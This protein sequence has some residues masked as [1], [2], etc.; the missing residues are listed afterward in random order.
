MR[1][2]PGRRPGNHRKRRREGKTCGN[3]GWGGWPKGSL[4]VGGDE[5]RIHKH[6]QEEIS[7]LDSGLVS[8][9]EKRVT[10]S[11]GP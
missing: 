11:G 8:N 4:R 1:N 6:P 10:M 5:R 2:H 3:V 9:G 7:H